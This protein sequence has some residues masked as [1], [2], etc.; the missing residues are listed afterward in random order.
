MDIV[1]EADWILLST[2]NFRCHYCFWT[3]NQL[4]SRI[5][6]P[7]SI[8][9]AAQFFDDTQFTWLLHLTGG[10]PFIYP[11]FIELCKKLTRH[12]FI[13]LNTNL[14]LPGI[15]RF[16]DCVDP[17]R[18]VYVN[19]GLH[20][21]ERNRHRGMPIFIENASRL[22]EKGFRFFISLVMHPDQFYLFDRL[23]KQFQELEMVLVPKVFQGVYQDKSFPAAYSPEEKRRFKEYSLAAEDLLSKSGEWANTIP[24]INLSL[25]RD[26]IDHGLPDF[27]GKL[28]LAGNQFVRIRENGDIRRC[29]PS[30]VLGNWVNRSF[31]RR[32]G[33]SVCRE[34]ECPYFCIKYRL[35]LTD[36]RTSFSGDIPSK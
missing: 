32:P 3:P 12:H 17:Q 18:V 10:E 30:D 2:C 7:G 24:T 29:G 14:S 9:E 8:D 36:Y 25:D 16:V 20:A 5:I 34:V 1:I 19:A 26:F 21:L 28:C 15:S 31:E 27:R 4:S 35:P 11:G 23:F 6:P 22:Q 13:S 33:P